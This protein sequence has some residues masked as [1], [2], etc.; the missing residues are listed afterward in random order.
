MSTAAVANLEDTLLFSVVKYSK[1]TMYYYS[2]TLSALEH[3][4][5]FVLRTV[6]FTIVILK[7]SLLIYIYISLRAC[8]RGLLVDE[9]LFFI[10]S[11]M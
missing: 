6:T 3:T 8:V 11:I 4:P 5:T 9:V 7:Y 2:S 1:T 10:Y